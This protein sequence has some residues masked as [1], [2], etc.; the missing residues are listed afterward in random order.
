MPETTRIDLRLTPEAKARLVALAQR[1][2]RSVNA[3]IAVLIE[4]ATR[5]ESK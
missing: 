4:A 1:E 5:E 3:Q 2:H